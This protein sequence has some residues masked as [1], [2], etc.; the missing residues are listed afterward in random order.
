MNRRKTLFLL[1]GALLLAALATLPWQ[2]QQWKTLQQERAKTATEEARLQRIAQE[3]QR[4]RQA[5]LAPAEDPTSRLAAAETLVRNG[6]G[7]RALPLLQALENTGSTDPNLLSTLGDLYRQIGRVDRAYALLIKALSQ[8]PKDPATLVRLGYLELSLGQR[9]AGQAH[10]Q[11]AQK[12]APTQP[13]PLLAEA[14]YQ[15]QEKHYPEAE[16]LLTQALRL[17]PE[18]WNIAALLADNQG[19]QGHHDQALAQ[20]ET[21]IQKYPGEPALLAQK[22]RSLLDAADAQPD[23]AQQRR[24]EAIEVAQQCIRLAPSDASL[25]FELGRAYQGQ[26]DDTKA[27]AAWE[28]AYRLKP[29]YSRLGTRLG[30]LLIRKGQTERGRALIA[31]ESRLEQEKTEF[32][33]EAGKS[34]QAW[35]DLSARRRFARW[36]EEHHRTA[37]AI[38]EWRRIQ[39]DFP[40]DTE[41]KAQLP[42]LEAGTIE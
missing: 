7:S 21:L 38:L 31:Q 5:R 26:G 37:R 8:S 22:V 28:E 30:Q 1:L 23:K 39:E 13:E 35:H 6:D 4:L 20:L 36:C 29:T 10:F 15:D 3:D 16:Q 17:R 40:Q 27:Q 14:L 12:S 34:A 18:G 33:V 19:K 9:A 32:A 11:S 42:R 24:T 25:H 41:A 2:L